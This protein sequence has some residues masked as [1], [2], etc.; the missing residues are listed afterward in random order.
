M[1]AFRFVRQ[2]YR[3][4]IPAALLTALG[5]G[6]GAGL[7]S[8]SSVMTAHFFDTL[9]GSTQL[10]VRYALAFLAAN[11][12]SYLLDF[13]Y[14]YGLTQM[15]RFTTTLLRVNMLKGIYRRPGALPLSVTPGEAVTRFRDDVQDSGFQTNRFMLSFIHAGAS[16][17]M[18][19]Y[20]AT[21][22]PMLA[23]LGAA[24]VVVIFIVMRRV[25]Q[26][27]VL[28]KNQT[29]ARTEAVTG[30]LGEI[31]SAVGVLQV[32]GA[33]PDAL[34][35]FREINR[36]REEAS[37]RE[38]LQWGLLHAIAENGFYLGLGLVILAAA[39][40]LARGEFTPGKF[41]LFQMLLQLVGWRLWGISESVAQF[42]AMGVYVAR[43]AELAGGGEHLLTRVPLQFSEEL[44]PD[45]T[46]VRTPTDQLE[47]FSAHGLTYQHPDSGRGVQGI[48]LTIPRG[49]FTVITGKVGSGKTTLVRTLL[50]LLSAQAGEVRWN[51]QP[52]TDPTAF[53]TPP[54]IAY[55]PQVPKIFSGT[56]RGNILMGLD[57]LAVDLEGA[58]ESAILVPDLAQ[59]PAG[60]ETEVGSRGLK[61][62]GGQ[63]Q[64]TAAARMFA[65][66]PE[67]LVLDDISSA[68]DNETEVQLWNRLFA[69]AGATVLCVSNRRAALEKADQIL[70]LEEGELIAAGSL[71]SLLQTSPAMR[72]LWAAVA[73][74][75]ETEPMAMVG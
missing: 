10:S 21:I 30:Y 56:V 41:A 23:A 63:V 48:S 12:G 73:P 74:E 4:M 67:L 31:F 55:T 51:G 35:R 47:E 62:S 15:D 49:S 17:G 46:P 70:L 18:F 28:Y 32:A 7:L 20:L 72:E 36:E 39:P 64:R 24:S 26:K 54:R 6:G 45:P 52:V 53:F 13:V 38:R 29:M 9:P 37:L 60:L 69:H 58:I 27:I 57:P 8:L 5:F 71:A 25:Q 68:L 14:M 65:R 11:V 42:Q 40:L 19:M 59:F 1:I 43:M 22:Q 75:A 34:R 3:M 61:L 33:V 44:P 66:R 16:A 50:G 2:L